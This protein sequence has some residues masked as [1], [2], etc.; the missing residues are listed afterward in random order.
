VRIVVLT[1]LAML[2]FAGN[3]LLCRVAL[4]DTAID[5]ATFTAVRIASGAQPG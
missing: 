5:A 4:R 2:A 3:S 1:A